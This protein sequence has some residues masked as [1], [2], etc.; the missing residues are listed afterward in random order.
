MEGERRERGREGEREGGRE[1]GRE[2]WRREDGGRKEG[3]REGERDG[4]G[5]MEGGRREKGGMCCDVGF[6][7]HVHTCIHLCVY[8]VQFNLITLSTQL[9]V[10]TCIVTVMCSL[11]NICRASF[12]H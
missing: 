7:T 12:G 1:G 3:E 10:Y 8:K 6:A 4:E 2:G 9:L 5:R 11:L